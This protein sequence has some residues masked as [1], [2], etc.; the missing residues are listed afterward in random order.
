MIVIKRTVDVNGA[1]IIDGPEGL[2]GERLMRRCR[3]VAGRFRKLVELE[4]HS[5]FWGR[6]PRCCSKVYLSFGVELKTILQR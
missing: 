5:R 2:G 4:N 1:V 6:H 3:L